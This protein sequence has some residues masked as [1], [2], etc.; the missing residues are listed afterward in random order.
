MRDQTGS[1]LFVRFME[2]TEPGLGRALSAVFGEKLGEDSVYSAVEA[3]IPG[4][5]GS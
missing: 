5:G 1:E 3:L 4:A 2:E